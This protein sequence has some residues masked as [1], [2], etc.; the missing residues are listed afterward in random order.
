[1][2]GGPTATIDIES[3]AE[4]GAAVSGGLEIAWR[5]YGHGE[6]VL[7]VMGL[8]G[9]GRAWYRLLPHIARRRRAIVIDNRGT[10]DSSRPLGAWTMA[11]LA[12]DVAAVMDDAGVP[13]AHV[14]GAS[15]GGMIVQ[16]LALERPERVRSLVL[17]CTTPGGRSGTPPWRLLTSL[18]LRPVVSPRRTFGLVAPVLYSER[19]RRHAPDR[20]AADLEMRIRDATPAHT[21]IGQVAAIARHDVRE[22][23]GQIAAPALVVHGTEDALV[24]PERARDLAAGLPDARLQL[25]EGCGHVLTTDA[26]QE[27]ATAIEGFLDA[28]EQPA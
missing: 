25:I 21:A 15:M 24:P 9:S 11:D 28:V 6:P 18:A 26:E 16:H 4:S 17:A 1:M 27:V 12:G 2:S 14:I 5:A 19:S 7:L 22:R 23:L 3:P 20:V 8:M 10:G 13:E